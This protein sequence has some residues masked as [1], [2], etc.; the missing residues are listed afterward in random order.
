MEITEDYI[1]DALRELPQHKKH[2]SNFG[3]AGLRNDI[4]D[5]IG[6]IAKLKYTIRTS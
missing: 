3:V 4:K 1:V 5:Y 2:C 6:I